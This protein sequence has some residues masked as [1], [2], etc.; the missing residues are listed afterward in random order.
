[1]ARRLG[2]DEHAIKAVRRWRF[3]PGLFQGRPAPVVTD[4]AVDFFLPS[5]QSR[6]HLIGVAFHPP[7]GASEPVFGQVYYPPGSGV[8]STALDHAR[9]VNAMGRFAGVSLSFDVDEAGVPVR[10]RIERASD[11]VWGTEA[12][13]VVQNWRFKPGEKNGIPVSVPTTVEMVWGERNLIVNP[14]PI[15]QG[16]TS[17][18]PEHPSGATCRTNR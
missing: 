1:M 5:R 7:E 8:A 12:L 3:T 16:L 14:L 17:S 9:I 6:W 13:A 2:L 10:F 15:L 4:I 11:T 18:N